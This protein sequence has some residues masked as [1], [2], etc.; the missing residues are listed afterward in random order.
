MTINL[1]FPVHQ[2]SDRFITRESFSQE[3]TRSCSKVP[4][5]GISEVAFG[6]ENRFRRPDIKYR[7]RADAGT[8]EES[9]DDDCPF[10]FV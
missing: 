4:N 10:P 8:D 6:I 2:R 3:M 7:K 9:V 5:L 1:I